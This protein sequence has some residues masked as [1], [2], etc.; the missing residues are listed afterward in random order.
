MNITDKFID[1]IVSISQD[2]IPLSVSKQ[3]RDS[4]LDYLGCALAGSKLVHDK[5]NTI[6]EALHKK[7][8]D[9]F[10]F[11]SKEKTTMQTAALLNGISAHYIELDDGH[12][13]GMMHPGA[14]IFSALLAVNDSFQFTS[15]DFFRATVIGYEV[16][17]RLACAVQ[18]GNK[19]R[20]YH[21][22]G[23]CGTV[24]VAMAVAMLMHL[25]R[26][27]MKSAFSAAATS[28]AGLLE[29]IVGDSEMKP[30]NI[31]R[32]AMDGIMSA[33]VG[34]AR[35]KAPEDA[36]GGKRGF[37]KVMTDEP[38][39]R[40]VTDF[41]D[42]HYAIEGIYRKPYAACRHLHP[43]IEGGLSIAQ[44]D[45]FD[46][47]KIKSI[48]VKTYHLAVFGHDHQVINGINSAKM[49]IPYS[50]AVSLIK[51]SANME[52]FSDAAI[53]DSDV[54]TLAQKV[55]VIDDD[56]LTTLCPGKRVSIISVIMEDET[57][58]EKRV[59]YPKGEPENPMT[60]IELQQK[61]KSLALFGGLSETKINEVIQEFGKQD[62]SI[63][64]VIEI[65]SN[66]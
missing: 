60:D 63:N 1:G 57:V 58:F 6:V 45:S 28:A 41:N 23:T 55:T 11:G 51:G 36:L 42:G 66:L 3:I 44:E 8:G 64:K 38:N 13:F 27:Q 5:G 4:F 31:G 17:I 56:E 18:P 29:M 59:D 50:V 40:Y 47:R 43:A 21:A 12:R 10:V 53:K 33:F 24:G 14:P 30:Y 7:H 62:F 49:S 39:L 19:L 52:S 61:F 46:W 25:D 22:T 2:E 15:A 54:L 16:A 48:I 65:I 35:F 32:A 26:A 37:L 34:N 20:G 9:T